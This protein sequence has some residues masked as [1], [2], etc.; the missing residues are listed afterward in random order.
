MDN[1][2]ERKQKIIFEQTLTQEQI[3]EYSVKHKTH[4]ITYLNGAVVSETS[5]EYIDVELN[6]TGL[7]I[8]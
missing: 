3:H 7:H 4:I 8:K 6:I 2:L 1:Q 5:S